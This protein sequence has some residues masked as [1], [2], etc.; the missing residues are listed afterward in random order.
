MNFSFNL[1]I[2]ALSKCDNFERHTL[3][4]ADEPNNEKCCFCDP[5]YEGSSSYE[6]PSSVSEARE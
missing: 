5:A 4:V 3:H 6:G 1:G 2:I